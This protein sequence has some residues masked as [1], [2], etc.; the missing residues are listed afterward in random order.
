MIYSRTRFISLALPALL[1]ISNA[2][3]VEAKRVCHVDAQ[4]NELCQQMM[5]PGVIAAIVAASVSV[6]LI[7]AAVWLYI[8][9]T[10]AHRA[11]A[12]MAFTVE[13]DQIQGPPVMHRAN[14]TYAATYNTASTYS[15]YSQSSNYSGAPSSKPFPKHV[16]NHLN[17]NVPASAF[18]A[19]F[20]MDL[21]SA[22][23][24][25]G[26]PMSAVPGTSRGANF[27]GPGTAGG[28]APYPFQNGISSSMP[29]LPIPPTP[30]AHRV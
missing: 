16:P 21:G 13:A 6:I 28:R 25:H 10:R 24:I 7:I 19:G 4:G 11:E 3:S 17:Y 2:Q 29:P 18:G 20:E 22:P 5:S 23:A 15:K 27:N 26:G 30:T 8:R 9:R 1:A 14:T 12:E